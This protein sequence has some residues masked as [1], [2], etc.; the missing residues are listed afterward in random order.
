MEGDKR[1]DKDTIPDRIKK[2]D[3]RAEGGYFLYCGDCDCGVYCHFTS[4]CVSVV[5]SF[6]V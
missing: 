4:G 2:T 5:V 3:C 6:G 1:N